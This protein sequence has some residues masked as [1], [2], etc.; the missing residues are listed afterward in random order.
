MEDQEVFASLYIPVNSSQEYINYCVERFRKEIFLKISEII[1]DD[2]F[3]TIRVKID[4]ENNYYSPRLIAR[5]NIGEVQTRRVEMLE[6][7]YDNAGYKFLW[8]SSWELLKEAWIKKL[9]KDWNKLWQ[10]K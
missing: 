1:K 7:P 8:K 6:N 10:R 5:V 3:Y 2:R 9:K 4:S